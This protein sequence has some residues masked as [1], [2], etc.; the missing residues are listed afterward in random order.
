MRNFP[1]TQPGKTSSSSSASGRFTHALTLFLLAVAFSL[2][3][4]T[5]SHAQGPNL[6]SAPEQTPIDMGLGALAL[7]GGALAMKRLRGTRDRD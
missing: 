5:R 2:A 4:T 6:P 7:A 1:V 3:F